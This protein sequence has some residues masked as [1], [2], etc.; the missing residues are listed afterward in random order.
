MFNEKLFNN[1]LI[2]SLFFIIYFFAGSILVTDYGVAFDEDIQRQL[3][4]NR[5]DYI[6]YFFS[7]I[8]N[9]SSKLVEDIVTIQSPEYGV[10]FELPALWLE[11]IIGYTE[12]R[13][14]FFFRHYL[15]F[16]TSFVGSIFFYLLALKSFNSWKLAIFGTLLLISSPRIFAESFYNSKDIIFMY[17]FLIN[18]FF[19][20][21]FINKPSNLNSLSLAL[22]SSL[23]IGVRIG[24]IILVAFTIYFFWIKYL[25]RDYNV[26][27][28]ISL[29][30]FLIS[31]IFFTILFWPSLWEDPIRNFVNSI[32]SFKNYEHEMFNFYM[33]KYVVSNAN[34]W[35]YIPV[36]ILITTPVFIIILFVYGFSLSIYRTI[37]RLIKISNKKSFNDLW[38]GPL[39]LQNLIFSLLIFIPIFFTIVFNSTLY[40]GW[41]HLYFVY[42]FIILLS[43]NPLKIIY[44]KLKLKKMHNFKVFLNFV[45]LT[46]I[47]SNFFWLYKNH[48]FQNSY[49]NL[50]AGKKPHKNFE[51]DYWGL[52]NKFV[53]EKIL[54]DDKRDKVYVSAISITS[55]AAN[56]DILTDNDKQRIQY[57]RKLESSDYI[58]N[59]NMLGHGN[60]YK[61]KK[62]PSNFDIY[63]KLF[64]DDILITTI[65]KRKDLI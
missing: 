32:L 38:R 36:W 19:V 30:I 42:P 39:E 34:Y 33:G 45:V 55:L 64:I 54:N 16:C 10:A 6:S 58:I 31:L 20:I 23:C 27:A 51:V 3:A 50:F 11:K 21:N 14:Q 22:I 40:S 18:T 59:N 7:N 62:I 43:L 4:Q 8:F 9:Q 61:L 44:M 1:K 41:R 53:L 13:S 25:R 35:H 60:K 17:L 47:I 24:G 29:I 52:S 5:L 12:S 15:I 49:F 37:S 28:K 63:Y 56:F 65:Y 26:K 48:P 57:A 2:V 46:L